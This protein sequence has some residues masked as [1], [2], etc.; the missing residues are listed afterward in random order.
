[1]VDSMITTL[2]GMEHHIQMIFGNSLLSASRAT[3]QLPIAR[4]G[5]GNGARPHIW[6]VVSSPILDIMRA[7]GFYAHMIGAISHLEKKLVGFAFVDDTDLCIYGSHIT[8]HNV[9]QL[10][11]QSVNH[12]EGLLQAMGRA[13]VPAKC[14]WYQIDFQWKNGQWCYLNKQQHPGDIVVSDNASPFLG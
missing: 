9:R 12:W 8:S 13:F 5:Q 7:D 6:V 4:I 14:F 11:Q 10:M 3:W 1:M 2:H